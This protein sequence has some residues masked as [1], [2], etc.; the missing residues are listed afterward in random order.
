ML[1]ALAHVIQLTRNSQY[2]CRYSVDSDFVFSSSFKSQHLNQAWKNQ[3]ECQNMVS[4]RFR[5]KKW[6]RNKKPTL[7]SLSRAAFA[8]LMP[9][10]YLHM[11]ISNDVFERE[12]K[13]GMVTSRSNKKAC[14]YPGMIL[15]E[16]MQVREIEAPPAILTFNIET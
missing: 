5:K 10:P 7:V 11:T 6:E 15:S 16:A 14:E 8:E 12:K 1:L 9:P 2:T 3:N 4:Q 13:K